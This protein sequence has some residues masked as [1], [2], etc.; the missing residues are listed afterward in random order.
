MMT[1]PKT[2]QEA[3]NFDLCEARAKEVVESRKL[4]HIQA[5]P[6]VMCRYWNPV[7]KVDVHNEFDGITLCHAR[8]MYN[9]FSCYEPQEEKHE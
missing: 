5:P 6:C 3:M 2:I 7:V 9:D 1:I 8:D 4:T